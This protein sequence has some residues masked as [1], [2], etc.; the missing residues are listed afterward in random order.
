[1]TPSPKHVRIQETK[2]THAQVL[3]RE[4]MDW[5]DWFSRGAYAVLSLFLALLVPLIM[6]IIGFKAYH[7]NFDLYA[8]DPHLYA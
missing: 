3:L 7:I 1:M 8:L 6:I 2:E 5:A 4:E